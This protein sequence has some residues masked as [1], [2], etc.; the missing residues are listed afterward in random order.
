MRGAA[1]VGARKEPQEITTG[2]GMPQVFQESGV[3]KRG[4]S[5]F[6]AKRVY[7]AVCRYIGCAPE[8]R[9]HA[10]KASLLPRFA[11]KMCPVRWKEIRVF[12]RDHA[13]PISQRRPVP[14]AG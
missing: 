6:Y 2:F 5:T 13:S 3:R 12:S 11:T 14:T 7:M 10:G 4:Q 9:P 1:T 8:A